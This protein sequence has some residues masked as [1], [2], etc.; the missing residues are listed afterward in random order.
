MRNVIVTG[1]SRGLGLAISRT[2]VTAGYSIIAIARRESEQLAAAM[3]DANE[4]KTG[5]IQFEAFDL[6]DIATIPLLVRG[7]RPRIAGR[8]TASSTMPL[9]ERR[10]ARAMPNGEI[11][12]LLQVDVLSPIALTKYVVRTMMA[13]GGGRIMNIGFIV[14]PPATAVFRYVP[15]PRPRCRFR[16]RSMR[17]RRVSTRRI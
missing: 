9:S 12:R 6:A 10:A 7:L 3:R 11:E 15:Q 4:R 5:A 8:Y 2:L 16:S 1:G 13:C 14:G 17:R